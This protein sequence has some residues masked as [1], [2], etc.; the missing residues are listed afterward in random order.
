MLRNKK[1]KQPQA[2]KKPTTADLLGITNSNTGYEKSKL[3]K[4][5]FFYLDF[6]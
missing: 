1:D 5:D 6:A 4:E 3:G 2:V